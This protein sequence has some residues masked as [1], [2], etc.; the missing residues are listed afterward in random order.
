MEKLAR[1]KHSSLVRKLVNYGRKKFYYI[2]PTSSG[3]YF[4]AKVTFE[5]LFLG[6][7]LNSF[8]LNLQNYIFLISPRQLSNV[9]PAILA[10]YVQFTWA[11]KTS[12]F[13]ATV[14][15]CIV[16]KS[17]ETAFFKLS[18][19]NNESKNLRS[20]TKLSFNIFYYLEI[21]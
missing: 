19:N 8:L 11:F 2:V 4:G 6:E 9:F 13:A 17:D 5:T 10:S 12:D 1:D 20:W 18:F 14:R 21:S 16:L 15:F 3:I 7:S